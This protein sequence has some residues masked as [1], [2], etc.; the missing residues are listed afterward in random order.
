MS[1]V[2]SAS[3][4]DDQLISADVISCFLRG[5]TLGFPFIYWSGCG[6]PV[7][8][9]AGLPLSGWEAVRLALHPEC[10]TDLFKRMLRDVLEIEG[11]CGPYRPRGKRQ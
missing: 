8:S 9:T 4:R 6:A 11:W 2:R 1:V 10:V 3:N 5:K 7:D